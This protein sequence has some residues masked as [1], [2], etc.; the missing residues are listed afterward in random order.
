MKKGDFAILA[1]LFFAF[2]IL[3]RSLGHSENWEKLKSLRPSVRDNFFNLLSDIKNLG[4]T[5]VVT[6]SHRTEA[7][8]KYFYK[9]DSRNAKPGHSTHELDTGIDLVLYKGGKRYDKK[10]PKAE[11]LATGIPALAK[12]KYKMRWG[13][14]FKNYFDPVHYDYLYL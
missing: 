10:T 3:S 7:Q 9:E 8:Q 4:F 14:D 5:P 1:F 6:S 12:N 13:G 2:Y 11:W